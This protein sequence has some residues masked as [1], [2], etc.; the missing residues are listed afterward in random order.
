[1][2]KRDRLINLHSSK[3]VTPEQ[4]K[5]ILTGTTDNALMQGE[6]AVVNGVAAEAIYTLN[7]DGTDV[8]QY[9]P[10]SYVDQQ[11]T[12]ITGTT[13]GG[14]SLGD[15]IDALENTVGDDTK[16]LVKDVADI[17][18]DVISN[19]VTAADKSLVVTTVAEGTTAKVQISTKE[20]NSLSL[21]TGATDGG[22]YV[23]VPEETTYEGVNAIAVTAKPGVP[24]TNQI[25]LKLDANDKYL[26]QTGDGLLSSITLVKVD[27]APAGMASQYKLVGKDNVTAIGATIDIAK[28]QFLKSADF[29]ASATTEDKDI[30]PT[31]VIGDPYLKFVFQTTNAIDKV[32]Y[33]AVKKLVDLYLAGD[34]LSLTNNTFSVKKD[35]NSEAFLTISSEGIKLAGVQTAIDEAK[36]AVIQAA[37]TNVTALSNDDTIVAVS[38]TGTT[39]T[40]TTL[41]VN[42]AADADVPVPSGITGTIANRL[43]RSANGQLYVSNVIDGGSF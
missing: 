17:K 18:N 42:V 7:H 32:T 29:V 14:T 20:G 37:V 38:V 24:K 11:I 26:S 12:E 23:A 9:V 34:G 1:M 3:V 6:I 35:A 15:R 5:S 41:K 36:A 2:A 19:K 21:E 40:T 16:G 43:V 31:V 27:P 10:K 33:V 8:V 4:V 22:L 30:D 25:T 13:T 39:G 28:D